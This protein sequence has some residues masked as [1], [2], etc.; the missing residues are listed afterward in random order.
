MRTKTIALFAALLAAVLLLVTPL[1]AQAAKLI[2]GKQIKD[3]SLTG[4]DVKDN[5]LTGKDVAEGTLGTVPSAKK[6]TAATTADSADTAEVATSL[7]PLGPGETQSGAFGAAS[8]TSAGASGYL[9]FAITYPRPLTAPI[10]ADHIVDTEANPD[11]ANCPGP[12]EAAPGY[13][14]LYPYNYNAIAPIYGYAN[15][16]PYAETDGL[17]VGVGLYAPINDS[18]PFVDGIWTVTAPTVL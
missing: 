9:G 13:L 8:A 7:A 11:P 4:K 15:E 3:S 14:C 1:G 5:S 12:G 6:A 18:E 16:G 2:T 17:W 10:S